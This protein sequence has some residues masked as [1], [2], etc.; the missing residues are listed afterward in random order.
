MTGRV[1][2]RPLHHITPDV[3]WLNDANG[4]VWHDG[5]YH[6]FHQ[7]NPRG[8]WFGIM[9]WGHL[10]SPDLVHW[11]RHP[12]A[13]AP[14]PGPD[15][16]GSWS[17]CI[18]LDDGRPTAVYTGAESLGPDKWTQTVCI[19][20]GDAALVEWEKD[21][22]NPVITGPPTELATVG[23][24]DPFLRRDGD[25]WIMII[26]TGLAS[27][28]AAI[29]QFR[30]EDLLSW[31]YEG[32]VFERDASL[33][34]PIW[35]GRIFECPQLVPLGDRELF[36]FSVWDDERPPVLHYAVAALGRF[37]GHTFEPDRFARFDHGSHC[38]APALMVDPSGR[39]LAWGWSW[40]ALTEAGRE[41]QGWAGCLTFPR[42]LF[43]RDDERLGVR[44]AAELEA[45]RGPGGSAGPFRLQSGEPWSAEDLTG[46]AL[47]IAVRIDNIQARCITLVLRAS[48]DGEERTT[49]RYEVGTGT[50]EIDRNSASISSE[51]LG[52]VHGGRLDLAPGEPLE[53]LVLLDRSIVEVFAN[54]HFALTER[55]YPTRP[56]S[57][58]VLLLAE[59]GTAR[60]VD[61]A[62]WP[63]SAGKSSDA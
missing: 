31:T 52:G 36:V 1:D 9:E 6:V 21:P 19:A 43:L 42:E 28:R 48:P 40:E 44:P 29:L 37:D 3:G 39:V 51:A 8:L 59:E 62:W 41:A 23:F 13:I 61:I 45:L 46:D 63:L 20:R 2:Q 16:G 53:L 50:L 55:I 47:E 12:T 27:R 15:A 11:T 32:P 4:L 57:L 58:G 34:E 14:S 33:T 18:V 54:E 7:A 38:Y 24:R 17:G 22:H 56:D 49:V 26:G 60:V 30:S 35:T 25:A 10:S 5:R